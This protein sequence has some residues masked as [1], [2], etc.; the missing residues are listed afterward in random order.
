MEEEVEFLKGL[1]SGVEVFKIFGPLVQKVKKT[2]RT[3]SYELDY[4]VNSS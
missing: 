2:S 4:V 3:S 1:G